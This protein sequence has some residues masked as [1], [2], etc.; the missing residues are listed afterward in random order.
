[1]SVIHTNNITNK[2][3]TSGPTISGITTVNSTGFMRVPV[4]DTRTR[5]VRD[6]ENIVTNGLV[7]HLDAGRA[8]SYGGDG[9][10]WRD[11]SGQNNNGTLQGGVGFTVDDGGSLIFD[12]IN[13]YIDTSFSIPSMSSEFSFEIIVNISSGQVSGIGNQWGVLW[14]TNPGGSVFLGPNISISKQSSSNG[15]W[16]LYVNSTYPFPANL[17]AN[18]WNNITYVRDNSNSVKIYVNGVSIAGTYVDTTNHATVIRFMKSNGTEP[19]YIYSTLGKLAIAKIYNRALTP[20]EVQQ[21][22][23]ALRNRFSI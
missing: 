12:A 7:L 22:F 15:P 11:L 20:Q 21:N 14:N 13:D 4:G 9:T 5:L 18:T 1:M 8:A 3:G 23:N 19:S 17:V 6:Y 10:I 16:D 2:D